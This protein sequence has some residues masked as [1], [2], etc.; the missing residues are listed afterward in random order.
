MSKEHRKKLSISHKGQIPTNLDA[1]H[2][3]PRTKE[4][5]DKVSQKLKGK[6]LS[7]ETKQKMGL[8]R[9]GV[10]LKQYHKDKIRLA[11]KGRKKTPLQIQA[12][13]NGWKNKVR[14]PKHEKGFYITKRYRLSK[15]NGGYHTLEEWDNLKAQYNWTCPCCKQ[16][17]PII[18]L[19]KDHIIPI[20][21][22]GSN[23]IE[24]IQPL[25]K[26]CN[27]KKHT[28]IIYYEKF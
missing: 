14:S 10:P 17:E 6:K 26:K 1:I 12:M 24:N 2:S 5:R 25:C 28:K 9:K 8:S 19:T 21:S 13:I 20:I 18:V 23:N 7:K 11:L 22:G 27:S 3:M 4:W 15:I 16:K